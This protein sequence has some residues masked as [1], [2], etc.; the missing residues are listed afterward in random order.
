MK[1]LKTDATATAEELREF[2]AGFHGHSPQEMLGAMSESGLVQAT[3]QA[4]LGCV[5]L[6]G[7]LSVG[8]WLFKSEEPAKADE[9]A[10]TSAAAAASAD[11]GAS[12]TATENGETVPVDSTAAAARSNADTPSGTDAARAAQAMKIDETIQSDPDSNPLDGNLDKLL[13]GLD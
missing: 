13:D 1:R 4:A 9:M 11:Q 2:I 6:L 8:P 5:V 7:V 10:S 12:Q 3:V